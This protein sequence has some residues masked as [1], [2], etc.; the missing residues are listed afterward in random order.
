MI[1]IIPNCDDYDEDKITKKYMSL[2]GIKNVRGGSY[3]K[4]NLEEWQIKTLE[5]EIKGSNDLCFTC[6]KSEHFASDCDGC[7][8]K[9]NKSN[10]YVCY[11]CGRSGHK[12]HDCYAKTTI[13]GNELSENSDDYEEIEVYC[14]EYCDKEFETLKG[15]TCHQNLYCSKN[16]N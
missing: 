5:H 7:K 8:N 6:G 10:N 16:K 15:L 13:D 14:C 4:I 1:E 11:R 2:Y 9:I 12:S 3:T